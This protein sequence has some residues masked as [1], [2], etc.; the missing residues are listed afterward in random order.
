MT[1]ISKTMNALDPVS[2]LFSL[3]KILLL[4]FIGWFL[5]RALLLFSNPESAWSPLPDV[6]T[7]STASGQV[8]VRD[9]DFSTDPFRLAVSEVT[10]TPVFLD[11]GFDV[12]ETQLN[13][14]L[15]GRT[16]GNPGSAVLKTPDNKEGSFREGDEIMNG[17]TLQS[18]TSDFVVL[19]VR[20]ELERL[21]FS[22]E[23]QTS[24]GL[25]VEQ[26]VEPMADRVSVS[27]KTLQP[28]VVPAQNSFNATELL[29]TVRLNPNF[30]NGQLV[31]YQ[32]QP[33][34]D[35]AILR[36]IGLEPGDMVT[37]VNGESLLQGRLDLQELTQTLRNA[38]QV[39]LDIIRDGRPQTVKI[40]Q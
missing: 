31:G 27:S 18:V 39:Q 35:V 5:T 13:L 29:K 2:L 1:A 15:T 12:P 17:V 33:R 37:A 3:A 21:T 4:I 8:D 20:G 6:A 16:V 28:Q 26:K 32:I 9:Y 11:P 34:G 38:R 7:V 25:S 14:E 36:N 19:D 40:G 24:L 30:N 22:K 23:N 10:E